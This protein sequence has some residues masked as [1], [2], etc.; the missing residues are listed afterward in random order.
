MNTC[1][2]CNEPK[3]DLLTIVVRNDYDESLDED[4]GKRICK[5][6]LQQSETYARCPHCHE[7][8]AYLKKDLVPLVLDGDRYLLCCP[9]CHSFWDGP[10]RDPNHEEKEQERQDEQDCTENLYKYS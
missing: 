7:H 3:A 8:W 4:S 2:A 6:C 10:P 1:I 5:T 9:D